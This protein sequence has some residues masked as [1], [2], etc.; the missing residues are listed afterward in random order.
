MT[1]PAA[2]ERSQHHRV[3]GEISSHGGWRSYRF[4]LISR[5]VHELLFAR[6]ITVTHAA[7]RQWGLQCGPA[8]ATQR[9]RRR[10]PLGA[11]GHP[12]AVFWTSNGQRHDLWRTVAQDENVLDVLGHS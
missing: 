5:D 4:P 8:S 1:P 2:P 3:P 12:D 7:I 9:K 11:P 6:G 10:P